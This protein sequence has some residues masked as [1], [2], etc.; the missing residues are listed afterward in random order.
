[1]FKLRKVLPKYR[2]YNLLQRKEKFLFLEALALHLWI[3]LLLKVIPFRWIPGLFGNKVKSQKSKVKSA[4]NPPDSSQFIVP[5]KTKQIKAAIQ[6]AGRVSPWRNKCLVSSLAGRCMLRRRK[7]ESR[8][9]LGVTKNT[10]GKI[11]AHAWLSSGDL[12]IITG[13]GNF[14]E[15]Y[16]F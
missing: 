13:G 8:L 11:I 2:K 5:E 6:R 10:E 9:S 4:G 3:G 16:C 7:I 12:E 1:M 15:L 14:Q